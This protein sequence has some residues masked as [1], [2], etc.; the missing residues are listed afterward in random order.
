LAAVAGTATEVRW[1]PERKTMGRSA[2]GSEAVLLI[3]VD[4]IKLSR[5]E[6]ECGARIVHPQARAA[7]MPRIIER[8]EAGMCKRGDV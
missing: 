7:T 5:R 3:R 2:D 8:E 1:R 4:E 6:R